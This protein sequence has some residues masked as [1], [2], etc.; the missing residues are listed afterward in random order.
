MFVY[1]DLMLVTREDEPGRCNVLQSP[2]YLRQLRLQDGTYA[3]TH[4]IVTKLCEILDLSNYMY[5]SDWQDE[6]KIYHLLR[7]YA[8]MLSQSGNQKVTDLIQQ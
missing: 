2:L 5:M 1:S 8:D 6:C 7:N 4:Q 3:L